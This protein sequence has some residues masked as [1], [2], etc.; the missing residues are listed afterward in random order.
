ML[1]FTPLV[2]A[3]FVSAFPREQIAHDRY[4]YLP[5]LGFI[6]VVGTA[7]YR[8][9]SVNFSRYER[10]I[11]AGVVIVIA[12]L[13]VRTFAY[14]AAWQ[15]DLALWSH[16]VEVDPRSAF[17]WSQ[18]GSALTEQAGREPEAL[19][20][21]ER[22]I[23]IR[24]TAL[25]L[26]GRAR[27]LTATGRH[28]E[29]IAD[30]DRIFEMPLEET[31]AYTLFQAYEVKTIALQRT[32]RAAEAIAMLNE[33]RSILPIYRA[34]LTEKIVV[35]LYT[36]GKKG[37]AL[38]EL[39]RARPG[40]AGENLAAS[41]LVYFR[42]GLL[43]AELGR[44]AEARREFQMFLNSTETLAGAEIDNYRKEAARALAA[45]EGK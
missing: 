28:A 37:E 15:N 13:G 10:P 29:A 22:S 43:Y 20:A 27:N 1:F 31:N 2:P 6:I 34:A 42:L 23:G 32:G 9:L 17:T 39:E 40:V 30:V 25:A 7:A 45:T 21:Y 38:A 5:L 11:A 24:P 35:L 8:I 33:A 44:Y 14:N 12:V 3:F 41:K 19:N 4:L 36:Q 16:A 18:L 26:M